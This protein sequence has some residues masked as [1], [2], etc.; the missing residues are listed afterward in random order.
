M[1]AGPPSEIQLLTA[2]SAYQLLVHEVPVLEI[3][4]DLSLFGVR[5]KPFKS[6]SQ[7]SL[8]QAV[9]K[10]GKKNLYE[11]KFDA[12]GNL[13]NFYR[14]PGGFARVTSFIDWIAENRID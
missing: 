14:F 10:L 13:T 5:V 1:L 12:V 11:T 2:S 4:V 3:P 8:L 9:V 6:V 7:C